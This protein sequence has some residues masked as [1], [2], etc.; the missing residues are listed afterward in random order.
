MSSKNILSV[1]LIL[2]LMAC[3]SGGGD[4]DDDGGIN[5]PDPTPSSS[6]IVLGFN[7]LGMH[8]MDKEFSVFSILPPF[9]V[10]N[11]HVLIQDDDGYPRLLDE[12][13]VELFYSAIGDPSGSI[14]SY[15]TGKTDFWVY[16]DNLFGLN[17]EPGE[18][19]TGRFM[20]QDNLQD[21][22]LLI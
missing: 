1:I 8:C 10:L 16:V 7:D 13:E 2:L 12:T 20:P 3:K 19:L 14:N 15:S 18:G 22:S 11:A 6:A 21:Q 17:L 9:N 4:S 5:P